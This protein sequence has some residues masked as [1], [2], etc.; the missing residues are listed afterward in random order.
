MIAAAFTDAEG[1]ELEHVAYRE[2]R[3]RLA[4]ERCSSSR[5]DEKTV[6][7]PPFPERRRA[8]FE[9][10][11]AFVGALHEIGGWRSEIVREIDDGS[12]S[13]RGNHGTVVA[14]VAE[15][16]DKARLEAPYFRQP[17]ITCAHARVDVPRAHACRNLR[18]RR[19]VEPE[20]GATQLA[21]E[22]VL[23]DDLFKMR[24]LID[25]FAA[26][27]GRLPQSLDELVTS[28][29]MREVPVDPFTGSKDTWQ[30]VPGEDPNSDGG[31]GIVGVHSGSTEVSSEGTPYSEW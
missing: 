30:P 23:R 10:G 24:T 3:D 8:C 25:Q 7:L 28:G 2:L 21:S 22:A 13:L 17:G 31:S 11:H 16:R 26:D 1:V 4:V 6:P 20:V 27:K 15:L 18:H 14:V 5:H 29:Y 12:G 9:L 19:D